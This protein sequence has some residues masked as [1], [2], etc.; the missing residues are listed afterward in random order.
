MTK[1]KYSFRWWIQYIIIPIIVG[2]GILSFIVMKVS[3]RVSYNK[4]KVEI[5]ETI[6][7]YY[8]FV[9]K[10]N[11]KLDLAYN[12]LSSNLKRR[13]PLNMYRK[14]FES[15]RT[16]YKRRDNIEVLL[17]DSEKRAA[18]YVKIDAIGQN[19][20]CEIWKGFIEF[21]KEDGEWLIETMKGLI[22]E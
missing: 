10:G 2:S 13:I 15:A 22:K 5:Q 8:D 21:V 3:D 1:E 12:K 20:K 6:E 4:T 18:V 16:I 9:N 17:S 19:D 7:E 11:E 14:S